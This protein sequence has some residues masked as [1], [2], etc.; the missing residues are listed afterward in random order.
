MEVSK[1][2]KELWEQMFGK[3]VFLTHLAADSCTTDFSIC[4]MP[5]RM[6]KKIWW[7]N[8]TIHC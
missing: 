7:H 4:M 6:H 3:D 8:S 5:E 2:I 1:E